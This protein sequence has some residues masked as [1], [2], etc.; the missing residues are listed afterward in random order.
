MWLDQYRKARFRDAAFHVEAH[1][2]DVGG[3]RTHLHEYP[4]RDLPLA[5]DLGAKA[6][7]YDVNA[8]VIGDDYMAARDALIAACSKAGSGQLVHPYLGTRSVMCTGC[9]VQESTGEGR[10]ARL[11]LSF[12]QAGE[13][14]YPSATPNTAAKVES[15]AAVAR[16]ASADTFERAFTVDGLPQFVADGAADVAGQLAATLGAAP[17]LSA[18]ASQAVKDFAGTAAQLV[19]DPRG[20]ASAVQ[21]TTLGVLQSAAGTLAGTVDLQAG[22]DLATFGA[23]LPSVPLTTASRLRQAV[24]QTA[25]VDLVRRTGVIETMAA[26]PAALLETRDE[27]LDIAASIASAVDGIADAASRAGDD[28]VFDAVLDLHTAVAQDLS[29]RAPD[30]SG[31]ARLPVTATEPALVT[32]YRIYGDAA[33]ADEL[34]ARNA[35]RHPGFVPGGQ[36]VRALTDG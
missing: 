27:A 31:V 16:A 30:L 13:V 26:V 18:L 4:G 6:H 12:V 17:G 10:M 20:L 11:T 21:S 2:S 5:E 1:T 15:Q 19:R 14:S 9:R 24:N 35:I 8:Y 29:A 36:D 32:A 22:L 23:D 34:A 3:R 7:T 28:G 25:F 33:R